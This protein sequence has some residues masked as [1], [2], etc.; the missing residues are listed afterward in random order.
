M[1][2]TENLH[3]VDRVAH[4]MGIPLTMRETQ[5]H[6]ED[7]LNDLKSILEELNVEGV[8]SGAVASEYQR[9]RIEKICHSLDLKS[10]T[11][12]WHKNQEMLLR[13]IVD[14]G[15]RA[16][17]V[18]VAAEGLGEEWLGREIDEA[19]ISDLLR[20]HEKHGINIS[21]EGGEYETFI[22]DCPLYAQRIEIEK[23]SILWEKN[24]GVLNIERVS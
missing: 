4:H 2:H 5:A 17:I 19:C 10:F 15:F 14:A 7:E 16:V 8:V 6:K 1:F 11:P 22:I 13:E 24:R 12:L 20:I 18:A 21:G 9:T 3:L 23:A